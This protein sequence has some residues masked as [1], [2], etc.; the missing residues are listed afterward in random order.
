MDIINVS[1][2]FYKYYHYKLFKNAL[3]HLKDNEIINNSE[4]MSKLTF[5]RKNIKNEEYTQLI[6]LERIYEVKPYLVRCTRKKINL[7]LKHLFIDIVVGTIIIMQQI[8]PSGLISKS[9]C[10]LLLTHVIVDNL[11]NN[12][13]NFNYLT[14]YIGT[15]IKF[16][17]YEGCS[18]IVSQ[19]HLPTKCD[20][21]Y[22]DR[23]VAIFAIGSYNYVS[24]LLKNKAKNYYELVEKDLKIRSFEFPIF[25]AKQYA[26]CIINREDLYKS[27]DK[28]ELNEVM[29]NALNGMVIL[30]H[31]IEMKIDYKKPILGDKNTINHFIEYNFALI[32]N[33]IAF[34][35][36][37]SM[38][39]EKRVCLLNN[40]F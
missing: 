26:E 14:E 10:N 27:Q 16:S 25:S 7:I 32:L 22:M 18:R 34:V 17:L 15:E 31:Q 29:V 3:D 21:N 20:D 28:I 35:L 23:F 13:T 24:Y 37:R 2:Q 9:L 38:E 5:I 8:N 33:I 6:T 40:I 4:I 1:E 11:D 30:A 36:S 12:I 39:D 19:L